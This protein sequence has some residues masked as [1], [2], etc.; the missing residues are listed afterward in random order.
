MPDWK[1]A[2]SRPTAPASR[3]VSTFTAAV[4]GWVGN[5][6][7]DHALTAV[8]LRPRALFE[9][10]P[11]CVEANVRS[12][13]AATD[14]PVV[15]CRPPRTRARFGSGSRTAVYSSVSVQRVLRL[16]LAGRKD[17]CLQ[18]NAAHVVPHLE[19]DILPNGAR[20]YLF[21]DVHQGTRC[22]RPEQRQ[23]RHLQGQKRRSRLHGCRRTCGP[24]ANLAWTDAS[25][26]QLD[27]SEAAVPPCSPRP[28]QAVPV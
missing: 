20:Q 25:A 14:D 26:T 15:A 4:S 18:E 21:G 10:G 7:V 13:V 19:G 6:A 17:V 11:P 16:W 28:H 23:F 5:H 3:Q 9:G 12:E 8:Q 2:V 27:A 1:L 22:L 24:N